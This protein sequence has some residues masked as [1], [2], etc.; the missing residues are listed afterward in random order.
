M[1]E[2]PLDVLPAKH[3][4]V[5]VRFRWGGPGNVHSFLW[6]RWDS[7]VE[8]AEGTFLA[9]PELD[10]QT[11]EQHGGVQDSPHRVTLGRDRPPAVTLA[12]PFA[13]APVSVEVF[14][15]DPYDPGATLRKT[16]AGLVGISTRNAQGLKKLVRL[17]VSGHRGRLGY[18]LGLPCLGS[19]VHVF[20][21]GGCRYPVEGDA[22]QHVV[23]SVDDTLVTMSSLDE[24]K[25]WQYGEV[26]CDGLR[27]G[28]VAA[29]PGSLTTIKPPP[30]E[31]IGQPATVLPGCNK[32]VDGDCRFYNNEHRFL[33][34]G[35]KMPAHHPQF[36]NP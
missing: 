21:D 27:L 18:V 13:H 20:G 9:A 11:D 29:A 16:F 31:W 24:N 28:I 14:E 7:D 22:E 12:R 5:A 19:C 23:E 33:G 1:A 8:T 17:D 3:L 6:A 32:K 35:Y 36:E 26:R 2:N 25:H 4:A 34:L 15:M 10:V 30:P